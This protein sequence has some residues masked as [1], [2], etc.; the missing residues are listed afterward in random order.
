MITERGLTRL[1]LRAYRVYPDAGCPDCHAAG[2]A[3]GKSADGPVSLGASD[4][5][6]G[7]Y[8]GRIPTVSRSPCALPNCQCVI[9]RTGAPRLDPVAAYL[10][11]GRPPMGVGV[12]SG[13]RRVDIA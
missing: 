2:E 6:A 7:G 1:K 12:N 9:H 10:I 11:N 13:L 5:V 4:T 8:S 3:T